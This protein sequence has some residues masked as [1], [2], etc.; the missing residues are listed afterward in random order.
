MNAH[1]A[2][3]VMEA[4]ETREV[5][6][7]TFPRWDRGVNPDCQS[8]PDLFSGNLHNRDVENAAECVLS[9]NTARLHRP[10]RPAVSQKAQATMATKGWL[11][12]E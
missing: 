6:A 7:V 8:H 5:T 2:A 12:W 10:P 11:D 3:R 9:D 4:A 1:P